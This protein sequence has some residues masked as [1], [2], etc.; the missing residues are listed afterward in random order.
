MKN[1]YSAAGYISGPI[2]SFQSLTPMVIF[3]AG[4]G[5]GHGVSK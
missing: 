5:Q 2:L 3:A 4:D 1:M